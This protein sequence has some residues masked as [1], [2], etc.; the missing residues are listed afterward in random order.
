M[1]RALYESAEYLGCSERTLRRYIN[2]GLLT[3]R[4]AVH[5]Q[6][7]LSQVEEHYLR[8]HWNTLS[9]L[10]IAL[11]T[12]RDVRLA[13]LFGSTAR[14]EDHETSDVDLL[15]AH[16]TEDP[17]ALATLRLR[18][19][20]TLG[21]PVDVI[22]LEQAEAFPSLF[23]DVLKDGRVLIDRDARW[24]SL[25][26]RQPEVMVAAEHEDNLT[27]ERARETIAAVRARLAAA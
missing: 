4:K 18:L 3:G 27:A 7:E 1:G 5:A 11:R 12:E 2:D 19:R 26:R 15:I 13:V 9:A 25:S 21:R 8:T 10:R 24:S 16:R 20:R 17:R 22:G 6:L 23:V 14:G